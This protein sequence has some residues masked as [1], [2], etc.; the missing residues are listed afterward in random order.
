[1]TDRDWV[2]P[3]EQDLGAAD[4]VAD[5]RPTPGRPGGWADEPPGEKLWRE[6]DNDEERASDR[7]REL[8]DSQDGLHGGTRREDQASEVPGSQ[9]EDGM[10]E[11]TELAN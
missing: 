7:E 4:P 9:L 1:M 11:D 10:R 5:G 6:T 8:A 3:S 2:N